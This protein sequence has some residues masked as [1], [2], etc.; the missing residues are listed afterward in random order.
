M[1]IYHS[2]DEFDAPRCVLALGTFD[3]VHL[4][5]ARLIERCVAL[6]R[7][8]GLPAVAL[9]FD[10]HPLA[11]IRPDAVPP[12]LTSRGEKARL[13][14]ALGLDALVE[15]AFTPEFA[16]L[17]PEEYLA[18]I[19]RKLRPRAIVAGFN[20]SYGRGGRGDAALLRALGEKLGY[21]PV[22]VEAVC[23]GGEAVS[24]T[25]IRALLAAGR[26][27]EAEALAGHALRPPENGP[28]RGVDGA[29]R[30]TI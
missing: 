1:R 17:T 8:Y 11:L 27:A 9:T 18:R 2:M 14:A 22:I 4:G 21:E 13:L 5:H 7:S 12:P 16:A 3:G 6:A 24:S 23:A 29:A 25:R 20:H 10:R 15:E 28:D 26:R 19:A 30:D